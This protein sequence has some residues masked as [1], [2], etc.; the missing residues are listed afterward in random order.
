MVYSKIT[1][2]HSCLHSWDLMFICLDL[3]Y[4]FAYAAP[5]VCWLYSCQTLLLSIIQIF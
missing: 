1:K 4:S 2:Y 5:K 3:Q